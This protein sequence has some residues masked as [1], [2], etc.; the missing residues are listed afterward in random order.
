MLNLFFFAKLEF[1][2]IHNEQNQFLLWIMHIYQ[3]EC[4]NKPKSPLQHIK[5][6]GWMI[7]ILHQCLFK[8]VFFYLCKQMLSL[9]LNTNICNAWICFAFPSQNMSKRHPTQETPIHVHQ[10]EMNEKRGQ[11]H[12]QNVFILVCARWNMCAMTVKWFIYTIVYACAYALKCDVH[13]IRME[14]EIE[15]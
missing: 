15:S 1:I 12:S 4:Q 6:V 14:M 9:S 5:F 7:K 10:Y 2:L 13:Q 11:F 8:S 3:N